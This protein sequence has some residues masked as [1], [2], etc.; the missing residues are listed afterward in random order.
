MLLFLPDTGEAEERED[1]KGVRRS[2][3]RL[4]VGLRGQTTSLSDF[5]QL[6]CSVFL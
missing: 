1:R 3:C 2:S 6:N 5:V 4:A